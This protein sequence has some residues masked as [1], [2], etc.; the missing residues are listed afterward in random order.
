MTTGDTA[1][2]SV[3]VLGSEKLENPET[4]LK[5]PWDLSDLESLPLAE[6]PPHLAVKIK[7]TID[8]AS[9]SS[10]KFLIHN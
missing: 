6:F 10:E 8:K 5:F 3:I 1:I 2:T 9:R 7:A 4:W